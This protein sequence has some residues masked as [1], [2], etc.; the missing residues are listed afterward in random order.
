MKIASAT[1]MRA[2]A[3]AI[4]SL[5]VLGGCVHPP[6]SVFD[7][8]NDPNFNPEYYTV[9]DLGE[10]EVKTLRARLEVEAPTAVQDARQV[11]DAYL[12]DY[13]SARFRDVHAY[14]AFP[15][16]RALNDDETRKEPF[17]LFC[18]YVN[19][20]NRLGGMTGWQRIGVTRRMEGTVACPSEP[21]A[22]FG[23]VRRDLVGPVGDFSN[24]LTYA[25]HQ[26]AASQTPP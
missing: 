2:R 13:P 23:S 9:R 6:G 7:P 10:A 8:K 3:Y 17:V 14:Y 19:A 25:S 26:G 20:P 15:E 16:N 11:L 22:F 21:G 5:L 1:P 18:G 24:A 4:V 12:I